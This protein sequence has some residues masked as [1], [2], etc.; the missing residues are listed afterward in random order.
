MPS[1][2]KMP[3]V[4]EQLSNARQAAGLSLQQ[5]VEATKLKAEQIQA[6]EEGRYTVF[7][8]PVY[9][10][11]SI[12]TYARLL[13]MDVP[14]LMQQLDGE[15]A[16]SRELSDPPP[17]TPPAAG[18]LDWLMLQLSKLD[19]RILAGLAAVLLVLGGA[20]ALTRPGSSSKKADPLSNLG[21]GLYT[22]KPT[23][24]AGA[25]LPL[26]PTTNTTD[27]KLPKVMGTGR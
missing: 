21:P 4:P 3:T 10:R 17:L 27:G 7:P 13:K 16:K 20:W 25:T 5:V 15:F 6:L 22:P 8:A 19:W 24:R 2:T 1:P 23:V 14:K 9:I 12:R 11:G 26:T 18:V